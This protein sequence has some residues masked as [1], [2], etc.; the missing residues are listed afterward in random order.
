MPISTVET[1]AQVNAA[2]DTIYKVIADYRSHHPAFLPK[3]YF[4]KIEVE[5]GGVG[6]GTLF[7]AEME[8]YGNKSSFRMRVSE[9]QPG[10]VIQETDLE[11]GLE[12]TFTVEP[13]SADHSIV[14][15]ATRWERP[16]GSKGWLESKLRGMIMRRIYT[17]EL[18]LLEQYVA[19]VKP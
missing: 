3:N 9:P 14:T 19:T 18:A 10:R 1:S 15:I 6:E 13:I 16:A 8:V 12:T 7:H 4:R 17:E 11:S 2:A 5:E